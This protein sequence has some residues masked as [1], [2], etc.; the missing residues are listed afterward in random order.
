M[1]AKALFLWRH[2]LLLAALLKGKRWGKSEHSAP[3]S[4]FYYY[5]NK[6]Q[7]RKKEKGQPKGEKMSLFYFALIWNRVLFLPT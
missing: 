1:W 7:K 4:Y 3:I 6:K 5:F 2:L